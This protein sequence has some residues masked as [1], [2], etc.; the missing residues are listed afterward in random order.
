MEPTDLFALLT[1][2]RNSLSA[3]YSNLWKAGKAFAKSKRDYHIALRKEIIM[4]H[5]TDKVAWTACLNM[6]YG[7]EDR[8][9]V[10]HLRFDKDIK[11]SEYQVM[12]EKINGLKL[13]IRII[14]NQIERDW[15]QAKRI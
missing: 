2:K 14:E 4:L 1:E 10:A 11:E 3:S 13:E 9:N 6:A 12:Q 8:N 7:D 15:G 5:E